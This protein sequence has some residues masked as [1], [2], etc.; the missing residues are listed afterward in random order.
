MPSAQ[1]S[2]P[3]T[4]Q[5]ED[6]DFIEQDPHSDFLLQAAHFDADV[7]E[8][9]SRRRS[10]QR[11]KNALNAKRAEFERCVKANMFRP[12][13]K[14]APRRIIMNHAYHTDDEFVDFLEKTLSEHAR[15]LPAN[16]PVV[17]T[18]CHVLFR[19]LNQIAVFFQDYETLTKDIPDAISRARDRQPASTGEIGK[20]GG[21]RR[22][23]SLDAE[24][25]AHMKA[26][27]AIELTGA[28]G[29]SF[30][31]FASLACIR[32][33]AKR[34]AIKRP[35][36]GSSSSKRLSKGAI[37]VAEMRKDQRSRNK[38][39]I[40]DRTGSIAHGTHT[41]I[42]SRRWNAGAASIVSK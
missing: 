8:S 26:Y 33:R 28:F 7:R 1:T 4:M 5:D 20:S 37:A 11:R 9:N 23:S 31:R 2:V 16:V 25:D 19:A 39:T 21:K 40:V 6:D 41:Q 35:P 12:N 22:T 29:L 3:F 38:P 14:E 36:K 27:S 13:D 30:M 18:H 15:C 34:S 24:L 17:L 10:D 42:N 32:P